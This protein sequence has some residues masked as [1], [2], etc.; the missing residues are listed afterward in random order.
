MSWQGPMG[1]VPRG[2]WGRPVSGGFG[3]GYPGGRFVSGRGFGS[4]G[5]GPG[6]P[7]M[8]WR[9]AVQARPG[10]VYAPNR[11]GGGSGRGCGIAFLVVAVVGVLV[12]GVPLL[13]ISA[14]WHAVES[15]SSTYS[16][17]SRSSAGRSSAIQSYSSS[18]SSS[19]YSGSSSAWSSPPK[20]SRSHPD[21]AYVNQGYRPPAAGLGDRGPA[22]Q[23]LDEA[24]RWRIDNAIYAQ[25]IAMPV[26]CV[27]DPISE[28]ASSDAEWLAGMDDYVNCLLAAW[29]PP[30]RAAGYQLPKPVLYVVHGDAVTPC[31]NI[32][33]NWVLGYYCSTDTGHLYV[34]LSLKDNAEPH[35]NADGLVSYTIEVLLGHEFGHHIQHYTGMLTASHMIQRQTATEAEG[36]LENRRMELQA[37]CFSGIGVGATADSLGMTAA[38]YALLTDPARRGSSETHGTAAHRA[39]WLAVG[40]G[41][42]GAIGAC[43]TYVAAPED[44]A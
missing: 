22:P 7:G 26:R 8:G 11:V 15:S 10:M 43:N 35:Y 31:G 27:V 19:S 33:A 42:A 28:T 37:Q 5:Y 23:T 40:F 3:A 44:V 21:G 1:G 29:D 17:S 39:G 14:A 25:R 20:P 34:N 4:G 12:I 2:G 41:A 38:D 30:M 32:D 18:S 16:F 6:V 24:W 13:L 36:N 9:G